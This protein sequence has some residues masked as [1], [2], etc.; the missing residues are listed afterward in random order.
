[1]ESVIAAINSLKS[2]GNYSQ[3][4][5]HLRLEEAFRPE[6]GGRQN[7]RSIAVL[8]SDRDIINVKEKDEIILMV[9]FAT[10]RAY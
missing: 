7:V 9:G 10:E 3:E 8:L 1:M 4:P 5:L 2:F 6:N